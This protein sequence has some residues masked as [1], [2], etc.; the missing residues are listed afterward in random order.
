MTSARILVVDDEPAM[1]R[2]VERI[3]SDEH[4]VRSSLSPLEALEIAREFRPHLA[5]VDIRM[6][7]MDGFK[8]MNALKR[9]DK[10]LQVILMTGSVYDVDQKLIRA[11]REKAFYYINKPFD[12]EVLR[13]LV[14]RC[15]ELRGAEDANRKYVAHLEGQLAE[16]RAFQESMLPAPKASVEG[17]SICAAH[18]PTVELAGDLYDYAAAGDGTVAVL[19][20][21]VVGHGASAAMLT[22]IVK[23]AFHSS[24]AEAYDPSAVVKRVSEGISAFASDRFVTLLCARIS[25]PDKTLEFVNAGHEGGLLRLS[26]GSIL[27]LESTGPLISPALPG[28]EW[29]RERTTWDKGSTLLLYTD[30]IPEA[31]NDKEFFG[32]DR[33]GATL[34]RHAADGTGLLEAMLK[35]VD[36][37]SGGRPPADDM[38]LLT[39]RRGSRG[40]SSGS[41]RSRGR[42]FL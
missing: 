36:R 6:E 4:E 40:S 22:G 24:H 41:R 33:I 34:E 23:A 39:A 19:V 17:F 29:K 28:M 10:D 16:V 7:G 14:D 21:D 25:A 35:E 30:G 32:A 11:I 9:L 26:D 20:A 18:K 13:T 42:S 31:S 27:G 2:S 12:R 8:L 37:F 38:T 1:L 5:V 15:L 3:L